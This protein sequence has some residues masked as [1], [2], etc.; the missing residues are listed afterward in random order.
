MTL[1]SPSARR[2][3]HVRGR[4]NYQ[5]DLGIGREKTVH[6]AKQAFGVTI[7]WLMVSLP[8]FL[9]TSRAATELAS[10]GLAVLTLC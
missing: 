5:I 3:E 1:S 6:S 8:V 10:W 9:A 2:R 7:P 4:W